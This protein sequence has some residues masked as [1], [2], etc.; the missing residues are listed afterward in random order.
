M[1]VG[2]LAHL[3]GS[4]PYKE[5]PAKV[6]ASGFT[7]VQLALWKAIGD[8]D[9]S[10]PGNLSPG[11]AGA[12]GE[13]FDKNG[14]AISVLGCYVHLF[15][16]DEAQRRRNVARFKELL[17]YARDF[18]A[19]MVAAETGRHGDGVYTD[20]DW[21][22]MKA[23]LEELAEEAE[24]R[25]VFVGLEA[26][27][28][29]LVGTASELARMLEEV[30][31]PN[32]G[33]VIDPGNLLTADNFAR[34]NEVIEE[35]FALLGSRVIAAHAKDRMPLADGSLGTATAGLGAMNYELYMKLLNRYKPHVHII[36]EEAKEHQMAQSKAYIEGIRGRV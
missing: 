4:L 3:F 34:Q 23:T 19:P 16:R 21:A 32:V 6:A 35:A 31:S 18:G 2:V 12:V 10:E 11:L 14:V 9:F 25:G 22:V 20:R 5:L 8:I 27:Q 28:G 24:K 17:R 1:S 15:D 36:M 7:H 13:Q 29:H 33:V 26:A 30:P